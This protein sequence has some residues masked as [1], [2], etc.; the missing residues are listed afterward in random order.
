MTQN[1]LENQK[2]ETT[3]S[4][5]LIGIFVPGV[6]FV[7][8][9]ACLAIWWNV[10]PYWLASISAGTIVAI[11]TLVVLVLA[12]I[13]GIHFIT[14]EDLASI[15]NRLSREKIVTV[16]LLVSVFGIVPACVA[17]WWAVLPYWISVPISGVI[18]SIGVALVYCFSLEYYRDWK[19]DRD[20]RKNQ[21]INV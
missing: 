4:D 9:P 3:L 6:I 14:Q 13:L 8:I 10:L 21:W 16:I 20:S 5:R 18:F 11:T 17:V 1:K 15:E 2:V 19:K 7:I 12:L